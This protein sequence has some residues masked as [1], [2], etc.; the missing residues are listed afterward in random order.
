[1]SKLM[2]ILSNEI[3]NDPIGFVENVLNG[4]PWK[5]QKEIL[6]AVRDGREVA[7]KS[8][9]GAGKSWVGG[10]IVTWYIPAFPYSIAWTTAPTSRQVYNILWQEIRSTINK[11]AIPLGGNLLKTRWEIDDKWFA[12]GFATDKGEQFQGLHSESSNILGVVDEASGVDDLIFEAAEGSLSS[13][14]A[15]LLMMGNPTKRTGYFANSFKR[16]GVTKITISCFDTPNFVANGI[17]TIEQLKNFDVNSA[18]IVAPHLIIPRWALGIIEKYGENSNNVLV[19]V[20]GEF[21]DKD[22]DTLI[23]VDEVERAFNRQVIVNDSDEEVIAC[24]PARYGNDRTAIIIR[25]G[26]KVF[27][28]IVVTQ[29]ATTAVSGKLIALKREYPKAIIKIDSIGLGAGVHDEVMEMAKDKG[30]SK[31]VVAVNVAENAINQNEYKNLRTEIW[32]NLRDWLK[33]G[34]LPKDDDFLEMAEVKYSFNSKGQQVLEEK[35]EIKKRIKK[36]PDVGD[37]LAISF[38]EKQKVTQPNIR[39]L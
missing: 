28:K 18:K 34:S 17:K 15:K 1:M 31:D 29:Y 26:L 36:S 11:A 27:K 21:P 30:F 16:K 12:Y 22:S 32:F 35:E 13:D 6:L 24:D 20:L 10:K 3:R 38:A 9:H 19:R 39:L 8:C 7:V 23:S 33:V 4:V 5:K 2:E 37:A 14:G 25:K